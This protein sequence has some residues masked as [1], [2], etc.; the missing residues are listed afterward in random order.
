M[1]LPPTIR[2]ATLRSTGIPTSESAPGSLKK[3]GQKPEGERAERTRPPRT[4]RQVIM[5]QRCGVI[6][7]PLFLDLIIHSIKTPI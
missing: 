6:C 7:A 5:I 2:A 1:D 4:R 3:P